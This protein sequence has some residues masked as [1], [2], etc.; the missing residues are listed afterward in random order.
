MEMKE[1][2]ST[3]DE[4]SSVEGILQGVMV[5][6][7]FGIIRGYDLI[8]TDKGIVFVMVEGAWA[9]GLRTGIPAGVSGGMGGGMPGG[10]GAFIGALAG[11][12][13]LVA[14]SRMKSPKN[15]TDGTIAKLLDGK[16]DFYVP[17]DS[18]GCVRFDK[19]FFYTRMLIISEL[20]KIRCNFPHDVFAVA[21]DM[22][23][24]R[25]ESKVDKRGLIVSN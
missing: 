19:R 4:A 15:S 11:S 18:V 25:L 9:V 5:E 7:Q 21:R 14:L 6:R 2:I 1:V 23:F 13:L 16:Y 8:F 20:G 17:Y 22:I 10:E 12:T 3:P 24:P